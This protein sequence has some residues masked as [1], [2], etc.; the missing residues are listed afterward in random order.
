MAKDIKGNKKGF[1]KYV[2]R[3]RENVGLLLDEVGA[4]VRENTE[5]AE[6]LNATFFLQSLLSRPALRN[7]SA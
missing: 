5:K 3:K 6:L 1:F 4:L 2:S 7:P